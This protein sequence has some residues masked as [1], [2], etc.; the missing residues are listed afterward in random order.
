LLKIT[1][2]LTESNFVAAVEVS[3]TNSSY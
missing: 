3:G 1:I 2:S